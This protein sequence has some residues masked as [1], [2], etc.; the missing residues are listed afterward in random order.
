MDK[1]VGGLAVV[2]PS[3]T[4]VNRPPQR[5]WGTLFEEQE[6]KPGV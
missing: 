5:N 2:K 6:L 1:L 3:D 4:K